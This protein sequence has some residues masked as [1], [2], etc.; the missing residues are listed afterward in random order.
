MSGSPL[1]VQGFIE[2]LG[3]E[4]R[5]MPNGIGLFVQEQC[6]KFRPRSRTAVQIAAVYQAESGV[7]QI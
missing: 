7:H 2:M 6:P 4:Q 1:L 5:P 3:R